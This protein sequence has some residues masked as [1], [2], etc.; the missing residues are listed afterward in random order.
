MLASSRQ[1]QRHAS[2]SK[3]GVRSTF[4][5]RVL[6]T[7][8]RVKSQNLVFHLPLTVTV[9]AEYPCDKR[10]LDDGLEPIGLDHGALIY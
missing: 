7:G 10:E 9:G 1:P 5:S 6:S 8:L 4:F 2:A 3:R